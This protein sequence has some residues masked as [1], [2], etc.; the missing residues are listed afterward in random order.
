MMVAKHCMDAFKFCSFFLKINFQEPKE[1]FVEYKT[2]N[3]PK[4][5]VIISASNMLG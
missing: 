2:R 3:L 1:Y 4:T 5:S